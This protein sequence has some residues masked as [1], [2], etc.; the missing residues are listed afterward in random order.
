V[1]PIVGA[2]T[3]DRLEEN[4]GATDISLSDDQFDRLAAA[5]PDPF[6]DIVDSPARGDR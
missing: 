2:R 1:G 5:K 3:V 4:L 6:P